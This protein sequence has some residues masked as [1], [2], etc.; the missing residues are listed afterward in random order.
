MRQC[1]HISVPVRQ[2]WVAGRSGASFRYAMRIASYLVPFPAALLASSLSAQAPTRV[3]AP[4]VVIS[5]PRPEGGGLVRLTVTGVA[6]ADGE[7]PTLSGTM[8]GEPLHFSFDDHGVPK[9]IGAVPVDVSDSVVALVEVTHPSGRVDTLRAL[10][11][12]PHHAPSTP[13]GRP[14]RA[15]RLR[16]DRRFARTDAATEERVARENDRAREVGRHAHE[17]PQLWTEPFERPRSTRIT[18]TFGSGRLFN[19]RVG[20][21]HGGV[22]FAGQKGEPVHSANRGVIALVDTFF[23]A[24]NVI[25]I[26]HGAGVVTGYFH[27]SQVN[28]AVGDTVERGQEIGLVGATGRV[29]GPHL[30]WSA[31]YGSLTV[32][33]MDL[34]LV[35]G[36]QVE[37][38][39]TRKRTKAKRR[40]PS[41]E[42][43]SR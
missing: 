38:P 42:R 24:G 5:P 2:S 30:H 4:T 27:L 25:Y 10:I 8:A 21:S 26:D 29:T 9:A 17:T 36:G 23:L 15:S 35:T 20:S 1:H 14:R 6:A 16:V 31:R 33:P 3:E 18:S 39:R 19:G 41:G 43:R 12:F 34:I 7:T 11:P 13:G 28:V 22:D 32:N 40:S 37:V